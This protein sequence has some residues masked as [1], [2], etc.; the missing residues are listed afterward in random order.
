MAAMRFLSLL[1]QS[2][3]QQ[4]QMLGEELDE[5]TRER[6]Q[7][8]AE[9]VSREMTRLLQDLEH[10][11]QMQKTPEQRG[12]EQSSYA[13]GGLLHA[14][15]LQWQFWA[16][17]GVLLLLLLFGLC[18]WLRKRCCKPGSSRK[19]DIS[20]SLEEEE[21]G[22]DPLHM[23]RFA[24]EYTSWPLPNREKECEE[25]EELVNSLLLV[26]QILNNNF[27]PWL[28]V[29]VGFGGFQEDVCASGEDQFVYRLLVP[30]EP[31]TGHSF[32]LELG[33]EGEMPVRNSRLRVQLE[34]TCTEDWQPGDMLCFLH[35]SEDLL[36]STHEARL[37]QTLCTGPYLDV[38][39]TALWLQELMT[40]ACIA[41]AERDT[42]KFTHS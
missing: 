23:D 26:C 21:D 11:R 28:Q 18:W 16:I 27:M 22:E 10:R 7:Q 38:Q 9:Y 32:H 5:A 17:A 24:D 15:L 34:C 13:W 37:L 14:A 2:I 36:A 30:L 20:R 39:K 8:L 19:R 4:P 12:R 25:V 3:I 40:A 1:L 42:Y 6:M 33:T 29:P 31:P 41:V 35:H